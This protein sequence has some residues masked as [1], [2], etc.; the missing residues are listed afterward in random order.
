ME[1]EAKDLKKLLG[2]DRVEFES[3][4][5]LCLQ[6]GDIVVRIEARHG[7]LDVQGFK[8]VELPLNQEDIDER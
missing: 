6:K 3:Q 8:T 7:F 1:L 5:M 2:L 4:A